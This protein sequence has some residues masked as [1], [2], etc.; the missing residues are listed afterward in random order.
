MSL[1][2]DLQKADTKIAALEARIAEDDALKAK[3]AGDVEQLKAQLAEA[4]KAADA[5]MV[6]AR[7]EH[8]A[9]V[10]E[11]TAAAKAAG[12]QIA[13]MTAD[14]AAEREALRIAGEKLKNPAFK[15]AQAAGEAKPVEAAVEPSAGKTATLFDQYSAIEDPV[16]RSRFWNENEKALREEARNLFD[17]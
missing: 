1:G 11:L 4:V 6:A 14:L 17:R 5:A 2:K 12:E 9:K 7:A 8:D 15:D 3:L 13:K 10:A 16:L